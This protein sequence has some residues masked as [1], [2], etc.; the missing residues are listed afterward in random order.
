[1]NKATRQIVV[2]RTV[3]VSSESKIEMNG[4]KRIKCRKM[5]ETADLGKLN[6][7]VEAH[8]C[9]DKRNSLISNKQ[10]LINQGQD[11]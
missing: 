4:R 1:M 6:N 3:Q 2:I 5:G 7:A 10:L 11:V 9:V 8:S